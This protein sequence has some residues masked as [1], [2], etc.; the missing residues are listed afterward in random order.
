MAT[1]QLLAAL[2]CG[3]SLTVSIAFVP[4]SAT[5]AQSTLV[6]NPNSALA[7]GSTVVTLTFSG[8]DAYGNAVPGIGVSL[9]ASGTGNSLA[10][11]SGTTDPNGQFATALTSTIPRTSAFF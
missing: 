7:D 8:R 1:L 2:I 11:A 4:G 10:A 5:P 3:A 9:L 6:A